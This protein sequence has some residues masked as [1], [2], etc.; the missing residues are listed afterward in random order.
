M[1]S[2]RDPRHLCV[3]IFQMMKTAQGSAPSSSGH[4][5]HWLPLCPASLSAAGGRDTVEGGGAWWEGFGSRPALPSGRGP[6]FC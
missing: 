6:L 5:P 3:P 2:T 1:H 4:K